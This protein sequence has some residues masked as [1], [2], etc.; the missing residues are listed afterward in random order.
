MSC[1]P[2]GRYK[3]HPKPSLPLN[4]CH[5]S[6]KLPYDIKGM[7]IRLKFNLKVV[8]SYLD[9]V[10]V[11]YLILIRSSTKGIYIR[12]HT[13]CLTSDETSITSW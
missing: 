13:G 7:Y 12:G 9:W 8:I 5:S 11:L 10:L 1:H 2:D 4:K 3:L 6:Y